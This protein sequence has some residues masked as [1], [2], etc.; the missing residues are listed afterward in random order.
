LFAFSLPALRCGFLK[1]LRPGI[2]LILFRASDYLFDSSAVASILNN[3]LEKPDT[4]PMDLS[5][6]L[7]VSA[8]V[9]W[10]D[11]IPLKE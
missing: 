2:C 9:Q 11:E 6:N 3:A 7:H 8:I 10:T 4:L 1:Q 5:L